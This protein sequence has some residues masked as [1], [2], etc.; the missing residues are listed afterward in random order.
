MVGADERLTEGT[1]PT[2]ARTLAVAATLVAAL[3]SL[4]MPTASA[5]NAGPIESATLST[6]FMFTEAS[7]EALYANVCQACHMADG[8]GA[9]GAGTYPALASDK[10]LESAGYAIDVV[11]KGR[12]AMP[13][14]GMMMTDDQ[15]ASVINYVRTHFDNH[16]RDAATPADV[17]AVR[18]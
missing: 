14:V 16:Y 4:I 13:P 6:G 10:T 17:K 7:G 1:L 18:H 5:Q 9:T 2:R 3:H 12:H 11:V 8:K 15:V